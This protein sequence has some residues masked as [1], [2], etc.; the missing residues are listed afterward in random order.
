MLL[1]VLI[2]SGSFILFFGAGFHLGARMAG[3]GLA[4]KVIAF[5]G[6][7]KAAGAEAMKLAGL[8]ADSAALPWA[9]GNISHSALDAMAESVKFG[10][11]D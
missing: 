3:E 8:V 4:E 7:D 10:A 11:I 6:G 2:L 1:L 5:H 9:T